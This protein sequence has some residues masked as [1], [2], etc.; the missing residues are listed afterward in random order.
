MTVKIYSSLP[1]E[2]LDIRMKVFVCE[3][4]LT[5]KAD[6]IDKIAT[7]MVMYEDEA[8]I[9]TCRISKMDTPSTFLIGRIAVLKES[10]GNGI[11]RKIIEEAEKHLRSMDVRYAMIRSQYQAKDFYVKCGFNPC[12]DI[13][14]EQGH[15]YVWVKKEL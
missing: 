14:Y 6:D 12:S 2:A 11:G 10:R 8:A 4:G 3:Q 15:P 5:D 9:A 13:E 7:H 1:K